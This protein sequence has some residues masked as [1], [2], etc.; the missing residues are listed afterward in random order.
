[1]ETTHTEVPNARIRHDTGG[2]SMPLR[3]WSAFIA[4]LS[5]LIMLALAGPAFGDGNAERG[6]RVFRA[7]AACHSLEPGLNLSGPSLA[8]V[9]NRKAGSLAS[10]PRYSDALKRSGRIWNEKTLDTWLRDPQAMV[11]D[12]LMTFPGLKDGPARADL[13]AFL[14]TAS[15]DKRA[16]PAKPRPNPNLKESPQSAQVKSIR[17]CRDTYFVTNAVGKTV[18]FWEFNLRLKTDSSDYGPRPERPVLVSTGMQGDRSAVVFASPGEISSF[19]RQEC[20]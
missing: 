8:G 5:S 7:C 9:W 11:P 14:R 3:R 20:P 18:P 17:H 12:N 16:R 19:I 13:I 6:A 10:F 4:M 15:D 2:N 1:M